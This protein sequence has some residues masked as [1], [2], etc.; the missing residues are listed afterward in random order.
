MVDC[1]VRLCLLVGF[2]WAIAACMGCSS[3]TP[4]DAGGHSTGGSSNAASGTLASSGGSPPV[5][6][7]VSTSV[8]T[9]S[10]L[11]NKYFGPNTL[12]HCGSCHGSAQVPTFNSAS[13]M[14]SVLE[15]TNI[16]GMSGTIIDHGTAHLEW[17]LDWFNSGGDM[18]YDSDTA[19]VN[20]VVDI[21]AW[22]QA[23][24]VCP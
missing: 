21:I 22:E 16:P 5:G 20:A 11:Y 3:T 9:W 13:S 7:G 19:P 18:P 14:C 8:P 10:E 12:G 17:L 1:S 4:T 15:T 6:G 2:A 24:A 23:G